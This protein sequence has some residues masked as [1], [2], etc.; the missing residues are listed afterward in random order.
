MTENDKRIVTI[1]NLIIVNTSLLNLKRYFINKT[2][3]TPNTN[4][5]NDVI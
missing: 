3:T 4:Q 1:R 5:L 2:D